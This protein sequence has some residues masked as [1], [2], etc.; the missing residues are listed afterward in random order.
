MKT[1]SGQV[2]DRSQSLGSARLGSYATQPRHHSS[3]SAPSSYKMAK[4]Y[5]NL[6]TADDSQCS[7][8]GSLTTKR[9]NDSG[10]RLSSDHS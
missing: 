1:P 6:V 10:L 9:R 2:I 8:T 4:G 5:L 3:Q 7:R